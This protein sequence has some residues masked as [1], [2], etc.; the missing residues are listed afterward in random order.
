MNSRKSWKI[1]D[2]FFLCVK[3]IQCDEKEFKV[4]SVKLWKRRK[5]YK[6]KYLGIENDIFWMYGFLF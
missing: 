3:W 5:K 2:I 4:G 6:R 1:V